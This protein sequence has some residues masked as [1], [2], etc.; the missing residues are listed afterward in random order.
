MPQV[1]DQSL[2]LLTCSPVRYHYAIVTDCNTVVIRRNYQYIHT[3]GV[4]YMNDVLE[5][6]G[7]YKRYCNKHCIILS[8]SVTE[9]GH[10]ILHEIL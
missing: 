7:L 3:I 4:S 10:Y 1:Q 5:M 8:E 6:A 9:V 2:D